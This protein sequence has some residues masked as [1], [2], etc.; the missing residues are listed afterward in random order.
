MFGDVQ[1]ALNRFQ[2]CDWGE[3]ARNVEASNRNGVIHLGKI[4]GLY[5]DRNGQRFRII[6]EPGHEATLVKLADEPY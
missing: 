2:R 6:N 3:I 5:R 4:V 1:D